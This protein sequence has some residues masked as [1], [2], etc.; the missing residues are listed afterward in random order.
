MPEASLPLEEGD[1]NS[2]TV[3]LLLAEEK[4]EL[5]HREA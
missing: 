5:G 3:R 4:A 2:S 1:A